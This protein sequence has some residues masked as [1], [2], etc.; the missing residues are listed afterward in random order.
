MEKKK[1][2]KYYNWKKTIKVNK[3]NY[4]YCNL[5]DT[6]PEAERRAKEMRKEGWNVAVREIRLP[7]ND[8]GFRLYRR[9]KK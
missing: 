3:K 9:K 4:R 7:M 5:Y 8:I 6:E 2:S 1:K